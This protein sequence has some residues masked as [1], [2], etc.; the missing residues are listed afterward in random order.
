MHGVQRIVGCY[1]ENFFNNLVP[2]IPKRVHGHHDRCSLSCLRLHRVFRGCD[3]I[4]GLLKPDL[5]LV[6]EAAINSNDLHLPRSSF[7]RLRSRHFAAIDTS[8]VCLLRRRDGR[9]RFHVRDRYRRRRLQI[10]RA[11]RPRPYRARFLRRAARCS[12]ILN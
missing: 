12:V 1:V 3:R 8:V 9:R 5:R 10:S 6:K 4:A 2:L 7:L 11:V